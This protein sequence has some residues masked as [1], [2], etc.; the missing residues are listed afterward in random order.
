MTKTEF[1]ARFPHTR[2]KSLKRLVTLALTTRTGGEGT[3]NEWAM[4]QFND[5]DFT[6]HPVCPEQW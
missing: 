4:T 5:V 3:R 6:F 2:T 1:A